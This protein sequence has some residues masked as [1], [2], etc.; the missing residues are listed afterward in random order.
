MLNFSHYD[1]KFH[2]ITAQK[3]SVRQ[4]GNRGTA[5][6][7]SMSKIMFFII[8]TF[9]SRHINSKYDLKLSMTFRPLKFDSSNMINC[10]RL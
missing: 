6:K 2:V 1:E 7:D 10:W 5:A 9:S 8:T 4:T 3:L